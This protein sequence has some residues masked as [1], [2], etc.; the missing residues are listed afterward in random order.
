MEEE[1]QAV[2]EVT[3]SVDGPVN[4]NVTL[5]KVNPNDEYKRKRLNERI[6]M[7]K[8]EALAYFKNQEFEKAFS[9]FSETLSLIEDAVDED[10]QDYG[11]TKLSFLLNV[12]N[13][14]LKIGN[15][16]EAL[17]KANDAVTHD[18]SNVKAYYY[19]GVFI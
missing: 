3:E 9:K 15:F 2:A 7:N 17:A 19:R 1:E 11:K 12:A 6:Q 18:G 13:S 5:H 10:I 14:A 4:L 8:E 16:S